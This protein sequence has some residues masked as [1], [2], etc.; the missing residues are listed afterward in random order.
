MRFLF[1]HQNFPGQ[2]RHVARAL[3]ADPRH[4]VVGIGALDNVRGNRALYPGIKVLGYPALSEPKAQTHPYLRDTEVQVRR[5]Q[6]AARAALRL[7]SEGYV[8]DVVV[9]HPGWGEALFL[10]DLFPT[11]RHILYCEFFYQADGADMGFDPEFPH[12]L[13]DRLKVRMRNASQ[14]LSLSQC[15]IGVAPTHWQRSCFPP[16][17]QAR[18][19][20]LHEGID[21][22]RVAPCPSA[23]VTLRDRTLRVGDPVVTYSARNLEPY[24]GFHRFMRSLPGL[25]SACPQ[26]QVL[27]VGG[28][29]VSYGRRLPDGQ[30]YRARYSAEIDGQVDWSRIHFL[31]KLPYPAYLDVLRISA[32]HVYLTYPFVLSWSMLEAMAAG[33]LLVGSDTAPVREVIED[34]VNGRLVDFFDSDDLVCAIGEA[35]GDPQRHATMRC[36]ARELVRRDYDLHARCLPGWIDLVTGS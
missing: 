5:G 13:D 2:F 29:R 30:T 7:K 9:A 11:A 22:Q 12:T 36:N 27:I 8:P 21:T 31:G 35:L 1:V 23:S 32:A 25:Q 3:S 4:Q 20:V 24:R 17:Y 15:D 33:C 26:A 34:G 28:D 10:K 14:L 16:E 6:H 18:I 19:E